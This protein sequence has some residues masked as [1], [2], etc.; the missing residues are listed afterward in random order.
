MDER[1]N[2]SS[3]FHF[4]SIISHITQE[5]TVT[6]KSLNFDSVNYQSTKESINSSSSSLNSTIIVT[7]ELFHT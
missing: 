4:L 2:K 6:A 3:K 1:I 7:K 5:Y